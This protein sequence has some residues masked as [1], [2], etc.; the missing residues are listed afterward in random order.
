[1]PYTDFIILKEHKFLRNIFSS[2]ELAKTDSLKIMKNLKTFH[3]QF[4]RFLKIAVF[5]QNPFNSCQEFN[6]CFN[7][8]L[9][10]FCR[11]HFTDCSDFAELKDLISDVS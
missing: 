3:E 6:E 10:N 7:D 4:V 11:N 9:F 8:D 2:D 5:S 1:M